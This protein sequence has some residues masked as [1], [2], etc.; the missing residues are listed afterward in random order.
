[1]NR[2]FIFLFLIALSVG[3]ATTPRT[4]LSPTAHFP[5]DALITQRGTLTAPFIG[6]FTFN[7]YLAQNAQGGKRLVVMENFGGVLADVLVKP[8]RTV[9]VMRSSA[10]FK[11]EWIRNYIAADLQCVFG[12]GPREDCPVQ[13]LGPK[14]FEI[15]RRRYK[16]DLRIVEIKPGPQSP[17][18]F[19]ASKAEKL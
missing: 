13:M 8:D 9:H 14:H 3:C 10:A 1:M 19:D 18:M 17:E 7:G 16:L 12:E 2:N 4:T 11:P 15:K 5:A 6:Q